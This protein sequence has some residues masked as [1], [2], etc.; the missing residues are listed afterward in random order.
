M[1]SYMMFVSQRDLVELAAACEGRAEEQIKCVHV[2]D[3]NLRHFFIKTYV[4]FTLLFLCVICPCD[5]YVLS[6]DLL[7]LEAVNRSRHWLE[8]LKTG[9]LMTRLT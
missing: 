9:I 7:L 6:S 5:L 4:V 3:D 1:A 8:T 2:F